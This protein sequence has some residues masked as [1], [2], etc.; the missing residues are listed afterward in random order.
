MLHGAF[1]LLPGLA[2]G[3]IFISQGADGLS[4][5]DAEGNLP[6]ALARYLAGLADPD[7]MRRY[8]AAEALGRLRDPGAVEEA[9]STVVE[10]RRRT[11]GAR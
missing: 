4:M 7:P 2:A 8:R 5:P 11:R 3:I 10:S 9:V 1:S 6:D